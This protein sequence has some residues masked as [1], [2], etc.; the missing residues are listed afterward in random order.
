MSVF[1][2]HL[3]HPATP[4]HLSYGGLDRNDMA[5][6]DAGFIGRLFAQP[7]TRYVVVWKGLNFFTHAEPGLSAMQCLGSEDVKDVLAG[8]HPI[9]LG[10]DRD[11]HEY[12]CL[13]LSSCDEDRLASLS[14]YG[15]FGDLREADPSVSGDDGSILAYAK[16][17]CHWHARLHFCSI[18]GGSVT[19][20]Q[21]GHTKICENSDC[22][23][24]HFP[25]T[26]SAVI[27]AVTYEDKIL[28]GRQPIWPEGM[29]SVLAGFVE[30]GETLEHAVAREVFEEAGVI[31][32][33]V[34]Y[35]HSQ[36]WPFPASLMVGFRA[37]AV[38]D[39]L[40]I[41]THEIETAAWFS[42]DEIHQFDGSSHYLP[43]KLSIARRLIDE[44]LAQG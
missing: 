19:S 35:Q 26:D 22:A 38:S 11:D 20:S 6:S 8:A 44:W 30:P 3:I 15:Q 17:M 31:V 39:K 1:D 2:P 27:V 33:N 32:K 24:P 28:L 34:C 16:A 18:C 41:N 21:A 9:Y 4:H 43:R 23:A 36:P 13:D 42:R 10:K 5:R 14:E 37:E 7:S 12:L 40:T 25:R 29:L